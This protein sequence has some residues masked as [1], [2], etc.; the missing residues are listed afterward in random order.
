MLRP[1]ARVREAV[2]A[3]AIRAAVGGNVTFLADYSCHV[4]AAQ[5]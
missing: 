5:P 1:T 3:A 4:S 2:A